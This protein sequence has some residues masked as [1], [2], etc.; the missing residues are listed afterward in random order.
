MRHSLRGGN[1]PLRREPDPRNGSSFRFPL[2]MVDTDPVQP[3]KSGYKRLQ[4]SD[5]KMR[6]FGELVTCFCEWG[7]LWEVYAGFCEGVFNGE[8]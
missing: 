8:I 6:K 5:V 1:L 2:L 3:A 4:F 7:L